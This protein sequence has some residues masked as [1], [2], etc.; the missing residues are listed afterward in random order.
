M[1]IIDSISNRY[2]DGQKGTFDSADASSESFRFLPT[3]RDLLS[4]MIEMLQSPLT[5][6]F[7]N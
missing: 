1:F 7:F 5:T 2:P 3:C 6:I 4:Y